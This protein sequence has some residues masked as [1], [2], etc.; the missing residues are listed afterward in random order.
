MKRSKVKYQVNKELFDTEKEAENY[1]SKLRKL[2][3]NATKWR[4]VFDQYR[5]SYQ[6]MI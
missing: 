5:L 6:L 1:V 3:L 2:G 4:V